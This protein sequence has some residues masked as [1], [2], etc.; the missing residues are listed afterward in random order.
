MTQ[1]QSTLEPMCLFIRRNN[2]E[3]IVGRGKVHE[4]LMTNYDVY[5]LTP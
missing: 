3:A 5:R 2:S 1:E 4:Q